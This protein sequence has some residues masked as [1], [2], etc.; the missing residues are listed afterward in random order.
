MRTLEDF[1]ALTADDEKEEVVEIPEEPRYTGGGSSY[2]SS[3]S[4]NQIKA[5]RQ[6]KHLLKQNSMT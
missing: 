1:T 5:E 4:R 3:G 6:A 2:R